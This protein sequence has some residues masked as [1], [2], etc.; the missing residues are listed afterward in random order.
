MPI[1]IHWPIP[2]RVLYVKTGQVVNTEDVLRINE[3][4]LRALDGASPALPVH[5][6]GNAT[7]MEALD[8]VIPTG[9]RASTYLDHPATGCVSL[10]GLSGMNRIVLKVTGRLA[11]VFTVYPVTI[12]ADYALAAAHVRHTDPAIQLPHEELPEW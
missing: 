8:V 4:M 3:Q 10:Y 1:E 7:Q 2:Q 5:L 11:S 9:I 12:H 6:L